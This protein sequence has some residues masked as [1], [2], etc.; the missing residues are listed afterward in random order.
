MENLQVQKEIELARVASSSKSLPAISGGDCVDRLRLTAYKEGD[1]FAYCLTKSERIAE[2][3]KINRDSYAVR[4]GT[5][6]SG[7]ETKTYTSLS[8]EIVAD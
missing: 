8:S 5:L 2:L 3:L 1:D 7:K 6:L 4:V